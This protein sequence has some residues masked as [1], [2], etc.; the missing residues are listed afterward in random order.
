MPFDRFLRLQKFPHPKGMYYL[1]IL[2]LFSLTP[3]EI[4]QIDMLSDF[5]L[6]MEYENKGIPL[7]TMVDNPWLLRWAIERNMI[8]MEVKNLA[9][10]ACQGAWQSLR[11]L[12]C[13][14]QFTDEQHKEWLRVAEFYPNKEIIQGVINQG[15]NL[16]PYLRWIRMLHDEDY[17]LIY[18]Q[19]YPKKWC[20]T[21]LMLCLKSHR[22]DRVE[23]MIKSCPEKYAPCGMFAYIYH[24]PRPLERKRIMFLLKL[25]MDNDFPMTKYDRISMKMDYPE[26]FYVQNTPET[27][28]LDIN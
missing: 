3:Q 12:F 22:W 24:Y 4:D 9:G 2:E 15:F 7:L 5:K 8:V 23:T 21:E 1:N 27:T 13:E 18:F 20:W 6:F 25:M 10:L 16:K 17:L 11:M 19:T 28:Y 26:L 14:F